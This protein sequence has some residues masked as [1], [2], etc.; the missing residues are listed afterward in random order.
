[1]NNFYREVTLAYSPERSTAVNRRG[2]SD[3]Q[4]CSVME[5]E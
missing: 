2:I 1:M 3:T 5:A 4:M